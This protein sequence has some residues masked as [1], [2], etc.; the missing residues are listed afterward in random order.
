[1]RRFVNSARQQDEDAIGVEPFLLNQSTLDKP[2]SFEVVFLLK[3]LQYRYGFSATTKRVVAEWLYYTQT[4]REAELFTRDEDRI[5][6]A[7]FSRG[8]EPNESQPGQQAF[9]FL[10]SLNSRKGRPLRACATSFFIA[11]CHTLTAVDDRGYMPYTMNCIEKGQYR[12]QLEKLVC[13]LDLD[14]RGLSVGEVPM[15]SALA[16]LHDVLTSSTNDSSR[17]AANF[18]SAF[19]KSRIVC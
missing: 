10:W 19:R 6:L 9:S 14:I 17:R 7:T 1:M 16:H 12:R 8:R 15:P 4:I 3:G 11:V 13:L 2:S 5:I 18:M